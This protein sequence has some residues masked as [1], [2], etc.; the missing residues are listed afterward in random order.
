MNMSCMYIVALEVY[1]LIIQKESCIGAEKFSYCID[2]Y[3]IITHEGF[4]DQ[5]GFLK[6]D[7][8]HTKISSTHAN[9]TYIYTPP[10][11]MS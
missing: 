7:C 9:T 4:K 11:R 5:P 1:T 3:T 2:L 6:G 10:T 8:L